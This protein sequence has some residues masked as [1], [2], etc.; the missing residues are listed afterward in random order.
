MQWWARRVDQDG[1]EPKSWDDNELDLKTTYEGGWHARGS[2]DP[3]TGAELAAALD[4]EAEAIYRAGGTDGQ[5]LSLG[6]RRAMALM[7]IIRRNLNPDH[8]DT[9]VPPTV[10]VSITL[11]ELLKRSGHGRPDRHPRT[12]LL[13]DRAPDVP[14]TPTSSASSPTA[15]RRSSTSAAPSAPHPPSTGG[16]WPHGTVAVCSP[17]A[18]GHPATAEPTTS[19]GGTETTAR[20]HSKTPPC[21]ATTTITSSTKAAGNSPGPPTAHLQFHKPDG[22]PF[23]LRRAAGPE[24]TRGAYD[25]WSAPT[26]GPR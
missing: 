1:R 2:F 5:R 23:Q 13:R 4:S 18:T 25:R 14:A 16:P 26:G 19:N 9:Q 3:E 21:S 22:T 6:R 8:A 11:D 15:P 24:G 17:A 7:E 10:M 20:P 12:H